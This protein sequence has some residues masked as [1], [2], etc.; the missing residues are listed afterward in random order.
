MNSVELDIQ[1]KHRNILKKRQSQLSELKCFFNK[2][3]TERYKDIISL[4]LTLFEEMYSK[5][6]IRLKVEN[7]LS[8]TSSFAK[9]LE[10]NNSI[11][12]ILVGLKVLE[13][14]KKYMITKAPNKGFVYKLFENNTQIPIH[15]NELL[16]PSN[17]I[18][19]GSPAKEFYSMLF[20][21]SDS[22]YLTDF[23]SYLN[24]Q[25]DKKQKPE[26]SKIK[27]DAISEQMVKMFQGSVVN[28]YKLYSRVYA[29]G[30]FIFI[31]YNEYK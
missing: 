31:I 18:T 2:D 24:F 13:E 12:T 7:I 8:F 1:E 4:D 11:K 5:S 15:K 6:E 17:N 3:N 19:M 10:L 30:N 22:Q 25:T 21:D 28:Y 23:N 27:V 14:H 20:K 16:K 9:I 29:V 26:D